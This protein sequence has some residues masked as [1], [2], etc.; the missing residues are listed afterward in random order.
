MR[1]WREK[2]GLS[3]RELANRAGISQAA[4]CS[5]EIGKNSGGNLSTIEILADVLGL[6]IDEYVGHR[7][8]RHNLKKE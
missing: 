6:S 1:K 2:R 5:L 4:I 3:Q 8:V 7:V